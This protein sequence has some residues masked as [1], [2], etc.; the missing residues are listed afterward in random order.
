[1]VY[2]LQ[3]ARRTV[4]CVSVYLREDAKTQPQQF[5][6]SMPTETGAIISTYAALSAG[7]H[8]ESSI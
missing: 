7:C 8:L 5:E 6:V 4:E 3:S 2:L 1:M